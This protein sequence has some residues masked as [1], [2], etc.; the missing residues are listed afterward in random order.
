MEKT[1]KQNIIEKFRAHEKDTGSVEVQIAIL[2]QR[3]KDITMHLKKHKKD[4]HS[5]YG[6]I[7]LVGRRR[8]FLRYL[9]RKDFD[10]YKEVLQKMRK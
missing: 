5:R 10:K 7:K 9:K 2:T 4:I 1:V 6:L 8:R 3:I